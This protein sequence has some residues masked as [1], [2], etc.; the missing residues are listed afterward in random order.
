MTAGDKRQ[1]TPPEVRPLTETGSRA[2]QQ[3]VAA[4]NGVSNPIN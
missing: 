2:D 1:W 3:D 4:Q